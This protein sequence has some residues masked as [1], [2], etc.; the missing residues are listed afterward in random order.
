MKTPL[1]NEVDKVKNLIS[2]G[3]PGHKGKDLS[4]IH[5]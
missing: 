3:M 1:K 2:F 5:I 4:L